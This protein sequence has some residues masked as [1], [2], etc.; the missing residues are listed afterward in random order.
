MMEREIKR[1]RSAPLETVTCQ[2]PRCPRCNGSALRKYR[3][4]ADQGD[5]TS[6]SWIICANEKCRHRF[7]I[8]LE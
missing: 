6:L 8:L 3:S 1:T 2:R 4:I 5:G 7:R